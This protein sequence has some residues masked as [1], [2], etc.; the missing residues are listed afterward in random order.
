MNKKRS[1]KKIYQLNVTSN[2][3]SSILI[4]FVLLLFI[5][6]NIYY[7]NHQNYD[8]NIFLYTVLII[9]P[10]LV[11]AVYLHVEYFIRNRNAQLVVDETNKKIW[12]KNK[13]KEIEAGFD[14]IT[15]LIKHQTGKKDLLF[16]FYEYYEIHLKGGEILI[17]TNLMTRNLSIPGVENEVVERYL[18]SISLDRYLGKQTA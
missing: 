1:G 11:P 5:A 14:D 15:Q 16:G 13:E 18:P 9:L 2:F 3:K 4:I 10:W 12:Y 6:V 8:L 7:R 17:I